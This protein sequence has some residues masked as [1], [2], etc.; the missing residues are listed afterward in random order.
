MTIPYNQT[1]SVSELKED[2]KDSN[3]F[4]VPSS[5]TQYAITIKNNDNSYVA[6]EHH[7]LAIADSLPYDLFDIK[8][9]IDH[10]SRRKL[11]IH[12]GF[13]GPS[14]LTF[15]DLQRKGWNIYIKP[16]S[17]L[18]GWAKYCLKDGYN[19]DQVI[20][21]HYITH[22]AFSDDDI[23]VQPYSIKQLFN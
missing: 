1:V 19:K 22:S 21:R 5:Y 17:Y 15:K 12:A 20:Q 7:L 4:S 14:N 13:L 9:E 6:F 16:I 8:Y 2:T 3:T 18:P 23:G 11:H 10:S